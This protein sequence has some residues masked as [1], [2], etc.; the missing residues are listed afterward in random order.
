MGKRLR[1]FLVKRNI[2]YPTVA[3]CSPQWRAIE[4]LY[5]TLKGMGKAVPLRS[6]EPALGDLRSGKYPFSEQEIEHIYSY[7]AHEKDESE[8][9]KY[10]MTLYPSKMKKRGREGAGR[11]TKIL[12]ETE[13]TIIFAS[14]GGSRLEAVF[15][16]LKGEPINPP[17]FFYTRSGAALF[18]FDV[19]GKKVRLV[20]EEYLGLLDKK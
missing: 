13:G 11:L 10:V 7:A 20:K 2:P 12:Q 14:H 3:V 17:S 18:T 1:T 16:T 6:V 8:A 9:D 15:Q 4:T 19:V 5:A